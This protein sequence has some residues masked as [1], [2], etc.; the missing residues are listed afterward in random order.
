[1]VNTVITGTTFDGADLTGVD[2][3]DALIGGCQK[4]PGRLSVTGACDVG[5][6]C[7]H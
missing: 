4:C 1:M 5:L 3:E 2:F 6:A 7:S